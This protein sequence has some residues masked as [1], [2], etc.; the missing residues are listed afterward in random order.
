MNSGLPSIDAVIA[1]NTYS[2]GFW[3]TYR[4]ISGSGIAAR[5]YAARRPVAAA[6]VGG[7]IDA[8]EPG[9]TG[10]LFP[11]GDAAGL[12][13]AVETV[14]ARG[15]EA[16]APGLA[17]AAERASWPAYVDALLRFLASIPSR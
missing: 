2:R 6:A 7:L 12:A 11:P 17:R 3:T 1:E 4:A 9:G 15:D 5:A 13:Q 16:Y 8:V 10:E 14:L